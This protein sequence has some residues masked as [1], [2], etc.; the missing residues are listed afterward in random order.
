MRH[1]VNHLR[2]FSVE[3]FI[4]IPQFA[5]RSWNGEYLKD[6]LIFLMDFHELIYQQITEPEDLYTIKKHADLWNI[7]TKI[8]I[9][10]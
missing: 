9:L 4:N 8:T 2:A 3:T 5:Y 10:N 6:R 1:M 7:P